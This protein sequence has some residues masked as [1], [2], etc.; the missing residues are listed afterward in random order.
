MNMCNQK[1]HNE[2]LSSPEA[3][4]ARSSSPPAACRAAQM[5]PGRG[6]WDRSAFLAC[7]MRRA[8]SCGDD[9]A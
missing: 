6:V 7:G 1:N 5:N 8:W 4:E 2:D 9:E 3:P